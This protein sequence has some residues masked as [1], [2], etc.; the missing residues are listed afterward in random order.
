MVGYRLPSAPAF[1]W[2]AFLAATLVDVHAQSHPL[3]VEHSTLTVQVYKSG[4]FSAF[5]DNHTV[6]A[7]IA[8]GAI[9]EEEP[10]RVELMIRAADLRVLDPG[11][12]ADKRA[13]VQSRML[14]PDVLDV[15]KF[16][17]IAFVSTT[18]EPAGTDRWQ[19]TGRLTIHGQ[20]RSMTF[21]VAR[22]G[23]RYRGEAVIK[24]RDFGITPIK[25]AGG[26]VRVKDELRVQFEIAR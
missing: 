26:T 23:A 10:R 3:D 18:I 19:V 8:S 2:I 6:S 13:E 15:A 5:A 25:V 20:T 21:P 24:Q 17:E 1:A 11:L 4:L 22:T 16:P 12:A 9:S 7:P 14:G